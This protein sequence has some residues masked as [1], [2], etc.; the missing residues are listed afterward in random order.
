MIVMAYNILDYFSHFYPSMLPVY[1]LPSCTNLDT[2]NPI[3]VPW[4]PYIVHKLSTDN[5]CAPNRLMTKDLYSLEVNWYLNYTLYYL[6]SNFL[7]QAL[8]CTQNS[9]LEISD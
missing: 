1:F 6:N 5:T 8:F 9:S 7:I 2:K 3:L 4:V